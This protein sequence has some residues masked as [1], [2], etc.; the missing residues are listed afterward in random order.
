MSS[1]PRRKRVQR[2]C[3]PCRRKK[4]KCPGE[5]PV[6][7]YCAR[8][9]Q[10]CTYASDRRRSSVA[11]AAAAAA[12]PV[13][14]ET[15]PSVGARDD[16][17]LGLAN[18]LNRLEAQMSLV[19]NRL[20]RTDAATSNAI[21]SVPR[22]EEVSPSPSPSRTS[23]ARTGLDERSPSF[24]PW[25]KVIEVAQLY[26]VYCDC[27]PLPLFHRATF[28][29]SLSYR[30]PEVIYSLLSLALRF[31][32]Q[33]DEYVS[34]IP[35]YRDAGRA[36]VIKRV[37]E[38][39]VELSTLQC[40]CLLSMVDFTNGDTH[41]ATIYSGLAMDLARCAKLA[42]EPTHA[43][44]PAE[45]EERRRCFWSI[46][47]L[48]RLQ[49]EDFHILDFTSQDNVPA[50]PE[51]TGVA[52]NV[53]DSGAVEARITRSM[54][55]EGIV[56]YV[57]LISETFARTA[58]YVKRRCKPNDHPP[59]SP[60]SEY[61][62]IIAMQMEVETRVPYTH[63]FKNANL[64]N[65]SLEDLQSNRDYW[66]PWFLSQFMYH[67]ILCLLNHPLLLSLALR[68][69]RGMIPEIFL[70]HSSDMIASHTNW[71]IH[72]LR[73]FEDKGFLVSDP[74]LGYC[75]A[76]VATIELQLSFTEDT[77]IRNDKQERFATC[78][79]F[80]Q[81]LGEQWPHMGHM[82][83]KLQTLKTAV[84]ASYVPYTTKQAPSR[85]LVI[86]LSRFW[87]ILDY[88]PGSTDTGAS[89]SLFGPSLYGGQP[90][91]QPEV[92]STSPLPEPTRIG[93]PSPTVSQA[94]AH[95]QSNHNLAGSLQPQALGPDSSHA[96]ADQQDPLSILADN[97]FAQGQDFLVRG[98]EDW[99]TTAD[100]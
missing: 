73:F 97:Y 82:A 29:N 51:T 87:E 1:R 55:D 9:R 39:P 85:S 81:K 49:G 21:G 62:K 77:A 59:W 98:T 65:R 71:I 74:F 86:D 38:G 79:R 10:T 37:L 26:L 33:D 92:S 15:S 47:L 32:A 5:Q 41:H 18:R 54:R 43:P 35:A 95:T 28:L 24:P 3:E 89:S 72:F 4:T 60:E 31:S 84:S 64:A 36:L 11:D 13:R 58:S 17:S 83:E 45:L 16:S 75:A 23:S 96:P 94:R 2:A 46:C 30:D 52:P 68:N 53:P 7:S 42:T 25:D 20:E 6:C 56:A 78:V 63:R 80:V 14:V 66:G 57:I 69:H 8:L 34:M 91:P 50:R 40:L 90:R 19:L 67:T 70:Q 99:F 48:R 44:D 76:V 27:Q 12:A 100:L 22:R 61:S 88:S 93:V